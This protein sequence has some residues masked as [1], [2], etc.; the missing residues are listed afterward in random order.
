MAMTQ[1]RSPSNSWNTIDKAVAGIKS[2]GLPEPPLFK[3]A[4]NVKSPAAV[5]GSQKSKFQRKNA[6][7]PAFFG[8]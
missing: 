7:S 1:F 4:A 8:Q 5:G 2:P 3:N 6:L